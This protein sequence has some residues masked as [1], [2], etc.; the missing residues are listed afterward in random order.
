M[1]PKFLLIFFALAALSAYLISQHN[2]STAIRFTRVFDLEKKTTI[3]KLALD[4]SDQNLIFDYEAPYFLT[5]SEPFG[6]KNLVLYNKID[7]RTGLIK[8]Q[9]SLDNIKKL[10][11]FTD[12]IIHYLST[13]NELTTVNVYTK[14]KKVAALPDKCEVFKSVY[15]NPTCLL[16]LGEIYSQP[17]FIT[18]FFKLNAVTNEFMPLEVLEINKIPKASEN[19]LKYLGYFSPQGKKQIGYTYNVYPKLS[20]I[21]NSDTLV[22]IDLVAKEKAIFPA[23]DMYQNQYFYSKKTFYSQGFF[24]Q[25][26][27]YNVISLL[28]I[29]PY[30]N[31]ILDRYTAE[32]YTTSIQVANSQFCNTQDLYIGLYDS[33][34]Y[35]ITYNAIY[36]LHN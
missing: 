35:L 5:Y 13:T 1:K 19:Y 36:K 30:E 24:V 28:D 32:G 6:Q 10:M 15:L 3:S 17:D 18:G 9:D 14:E 33:I 34:P 12:S 27:S 29:D 22:S 2:T 26:A 20:I 4:N 21:S 25:H 31:L 8:I 23:I 11:N 16:L 7:L